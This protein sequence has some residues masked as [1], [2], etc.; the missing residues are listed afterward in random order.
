M[1]RA[2]LEK[3]QYLL[4]NASLDK[5]FWVKTIK[6]ASHLLNRLP[7]IAI[8]GKTPLEIWSGGVARDHGSFRAFDCSAYVDVTKDML[9]SNMNK[10]VFLRYKEDL[11]F[12]LLWDPKNKEF[13]SSRHVTLNEA[14][15][16]KLIV[17]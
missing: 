11:K 9:D 8:G 1:N 13:I 5:S 16:V 12:Y 10:L 7:T 6:Y 3:V 4:S 17:S 15:M 2:W 14:S